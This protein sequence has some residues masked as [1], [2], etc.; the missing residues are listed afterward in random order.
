MQ[1]NDATIA[2][3]ARNIRADWKTGLNWTPP[4]DLTNIL[5]W[6][7]PSAGASNFYFWA[8]ALQQFREWV[9][10]RVYADVAANKFQ[11]ENLC[12]EAS[13]SIPRNAILD[14]TFGAFGDTIRMR[15]QMWQEAKYQWVLSVLTGNPVTFTG[16][17]F[18]STQHKYGKNALSNVTTDA[19]SATSFNAA[20]VAAGAWKYDN[21]VLIRPRWTHLVHGAALRAPVAALIKSQYL[22]KDL[23]ANPNYQALQTIEVLDLAGDY[24]NYWFMIDASRPIKAVCRQVREEASPF[25]DTIIANVERLG[26]F[27]VL[28]TGRGAAAPTFP[29]LIYAGLTAAA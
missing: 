16:K 2:E 27:D 18:F 28:A 8:S 5:F 26:R 1:L 9:G 20:Y 17:P 14:D 13:D 19:L 11:V 22:D 6:D 23:Q 21:G 3:I 10:E 15:A 4:V 12:F 7:V 29:H 24:K 25:M